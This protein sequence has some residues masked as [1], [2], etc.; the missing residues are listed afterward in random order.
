MARSRQ[1]LAKRSSRRSVPARPGSETLAADES[2]EQRLTAE[3]LAIDRGSKIRVVEDVVAIGQ[4]IK[5]LQ[6]HLGFGQWLSWLSGHLP[7]S[8]R[9]A[10]RYVAVAHWAAEH[11]DDYEHFA[12]LGLG[13][14]QL[15]AGLTPQLRARFRRQQRF[16]LPGTSTRKTLALMTHEQLDSVI[17]GLGDFTARPPALPPGKVLQRFRHRL[18]GL[19]AMADQL[20]A[21]ADALPVDEVEEAVE[22]LEA[23]LAEVRELL[24]G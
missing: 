13:K 20:R 4:R 8:P 17:R 3:I 19:D 22:A 2:L 11:P 9:T 5:V 16:R 6:V 18:A 12:S 1:K 10:Q 23:V 21:H 7:F 24:P 14:L 15:I